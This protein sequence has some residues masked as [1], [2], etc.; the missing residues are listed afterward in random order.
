M[1]HQNLADAFAPAAAAYHTAV[2]K[3]TWGHLAPQKNKTY[4]G[5][6]TFALGI[7]GSDD[8][9]PTALECAFKTRK[10]ETLESSPWFF[11]AMMEFMQ[12]LQD[13]TKAGGVYRFVGTFKNYQFN[14]AVQRLKLED[15]NVEV[16]TR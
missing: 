11:D 4:R 2:I 7:F 13:T 10:G 5:Q 6:L 12:S 1:S 15:S 14:G 3:E 8:L 9:N 16:Q